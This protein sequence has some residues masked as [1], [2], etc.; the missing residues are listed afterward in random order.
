MADQSGKPTMEEP[1]PGTADWVEAQ[2][3]RKC[4]RIQAQAKFLLKQWTV[5]MRELAAAIRA[6][7]VE[8]ASEERTGDGGIYKKTTKIIDPRLDFLQNHVNK[9]GNDFTIP[10]SHSEFHFSD[11]HHN[12]HKAL[13]NFISSLLLLSYLTTLIGNILIIIVSLK[14]QSLQTPMYFFLSNLS[15]VEICVTSTITPK[16]LSILSFGNRAISYWG[17]SLQC[18]F[19]FALASIDFF[20]LAVMSFDRY[21]AICQPLRYVTVMNHRLCLYLAGGSWLF[22][23]VD[24]LPPT[25]FTNKLQFCGSEIEHF[26]CDIDPILKLACEDTSLI[27]FLSLIASS[28]TVLGSLACI[29]VSYTL[30]ICAIFKIRSGGQRWKT[31]STCSSHLMLVVIFY[32]GSLFMCLRFISGSSFDVN[33]LAVVLNTIITPM[34]NPFIYTLRN[35]QVQHAIRVVF[36]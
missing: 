25:I 7:Q 12:F 23:F 29:T 27:N 10:K 3:E 18:Y 24:T 6:R 2:M 8:A 22:G 20:L 5:E 21:V 36:I 11:I 30:I 26:F 34:L 16:F 31:F 35:S 9:A 28:F 19:Y 1:V 4:R 33:K 15:I 17:C 13:Q 14:H 32:S